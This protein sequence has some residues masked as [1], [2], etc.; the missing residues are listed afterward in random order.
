MTMR[1]LLSAYACEPGQGSE[2][3]VGWG[4]ANAHAAAG[5][6]VT[7]IT[8]EN[9]LSACEAAR[10]QNSLQ[11]LRFIGFDLGTRLR[12]LKQ[13][14]GAAG[15][16]LYYSAWQYRLGQNAPASA[17]LVQH[18]TLAT[19]WMASGARQLGAPFVWGPV[20]GGD[21]IPAA[22][23]SG[24]GWRGVAEEAARLVARGLSER[25]PGLR[26]TARQAALIVAATPATAERMRKQGARRVEILSQAA[27][28]PADLER[29]SPTGSRAAGPVRLLMVGEMVRRKGVHLALGALARLAARTDWQLEILGEG[30]DRAMLA[31]MAD[32]YGLGRRVTFQGQKS[33]DEVFA[34]LRSADILL[35]LSLRDSAGLACV[36][37][38]AAGVPVI[39][40]NHGGPQQLVADAAGM[41]L[42]PDDPVRV[43]DVAAK[44]IA[45]LLDD[46]QRRIAMGAAGRRHVEDRLTWPARH[47]RFMA[48]L[49]QA[50]LVP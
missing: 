24:L 2:P 1:I 44:A 12:W 3:E 48:L 49:R 46:P 19:C 47:Q 9:N 33:R 29:L 7:V 23:W 39:C 11:R 31:Q 15:L 36:E 28:S 42:L 25:L 6:D 17:D 30:R 18:V 43:M 37:A 26:A 4:W 34:A 8:R 22:F 14:G 5:H 35:H 20:G 10:A 27:L 16:R 13:V 40:L 41:K 38:M 32:R 45:A 50:E 21:D